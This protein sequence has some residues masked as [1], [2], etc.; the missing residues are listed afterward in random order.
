MIWRRKGTRVWKNSHFV[1]FIFRF[2][3]RNRSRTSLNLSM[4]SSAVEEKLIRSSKQRTVVFQVRPTRTCSI[5]LWKVF[6]LLLSPVGIRS[7]LKDQKGVL[8]AVKCWLSSTVGSWWKPH[9]ISIV[10][11]NSLPSK[12]SK[13]SSM[14]GMGQQGLMVCFFNRR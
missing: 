5:K 13:I 3:E 8:K 4:C 10:V 1:G 6:G 9:D 11:K 2:A 14:D 12:V 7:H